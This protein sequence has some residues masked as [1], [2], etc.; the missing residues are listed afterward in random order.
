MPEASGLT[1]G[2]VVRQLRVSKRWSVRKLASECKVGRQTISEIEQNRSNYQRTTLEAV[3]QA[4]GYT[5]TD[6]ER[7]AAATT[8]TVPEPEPQELLAPEWVLFAQRA[9][10]LSRLGQAALQ[11]VLM[12]F[13]EAE[14][15]QITPAKPSTHVPNH[16]HDLRHRA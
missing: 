12:A 7:M 10:K 1:I 15:Y 4:L 8:P 2:G 9:S 11:M 13:E 16:I 14:V 5:A 6:L 3:A